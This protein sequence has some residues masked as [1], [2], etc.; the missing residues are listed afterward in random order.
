MPPC[1]SSTP[2]YQTIHLVNRGTTSLTFNFDSDPKGHF[3]VWPQAALI[4]PHCV[5]ICV[6]KFTGDEC[7][8][9]SAN[10]QCHVNH[11]AKYLKTFTISAFVDSPALLVDSNV[12]GYLVLGLGYS[13]GRRTKVANFFHELTFFKQPKTD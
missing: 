4:L 6:I 11:N 10:I 3:E 13:L 2:S 7:Q 1:V 5:Q 8:K 9:Y 12:S